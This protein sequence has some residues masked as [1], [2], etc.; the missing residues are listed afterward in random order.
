MCA[1]WAHS[2]IVW[3]TEGRPCRVCP[4]VCVCVFN[5]TERARWREGEREGLESRHLAGKNSARTEANTACCS[6]SA[7]CCVTMCVT[8]TTAT[9]TATATTATTT[10]T[11]DGV[12]S[13]VFQGVPFALRAERVVAG[14]FYTQIQVSMSHSHHHQRGF[15]LSANGPY[16]NDS[17]Y[18]K[19]S[20][21]TLVFFAHL[22]KKWLPAN[23]RQK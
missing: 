19:K 5:Q 7:N 9:T 17:K 4:P 14:L 12:N 21:L 20:Q 16:N 2:T 15:L 11:N 23:V 1:R 13:A 6:A 22:P 3:L 8:T 10:A 18:I